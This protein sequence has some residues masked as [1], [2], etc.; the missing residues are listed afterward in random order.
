MKF[1]K[2]YGQSKIEKC[3]FC[4][5]QATTTNEEGVPVC[6]KHKNSKLPELKCVCGEHV[7]LM[8]GKNG[9]YFKCMNCG[10]VNAGRVFETNDIRAED[11]YMEKSEEN[12]THEIDTD[13]NDPRFF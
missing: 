12:H 5:R 3:P 2:V 7:M 8:K 1:R 11:S 6:V 4:D 9:V 10:N 13:T